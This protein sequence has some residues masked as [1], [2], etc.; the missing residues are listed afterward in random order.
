ME[1]FINEGFTFDDVLLI[2]AKSDVVPSEVCLKTRLSDKI[3][4]NIPIISAAMDTVTESKMA[5]AVATQG[6]VGIIHKNMSI[7]MQAAEVGKV[8]RYESGMVTNPL[9]L[10]PTTKVADALRIMQEQNISSFPIIFK[11]KVVGI[12]T[13]R[14]LRFIE[15]DSM[16]VE[17]VMTPKAKLVTGKEG[18]TPEL[19]RD[20][21]HKHRIEKL[22]ILNKRGELLGLITM[23]DIMK[24]INY[25]NACIDE[26][27]RLIVGAAIGTSADSMERLEEL[28]KAGVDIITVDTAHGHSSGVLKMVKKVKTRF[29]D[30]TVVGGNIATGDAARD[31]INAGADSI[32]VGI[33]PGSICT[34]RIVAGV[35]VPQVTAVNDCYQVARERNVT[36]IADG[37][38][39]Y[40]GDIA[41]AIA[42][43]ADVVMIG[44]LFAG[45]EESPGEKILFEGRQFKQYRGMGS[46]GAMKLGSKDRYF[47]S[48][49]TESEKMVP[50]GIEGRVPYRGYVSDTIYQ[51]IGGLRA[52]MGYCGCETIEKMKTATFTRITG[53]GLKESHPHDVQI[54]KEAPN[55]KLG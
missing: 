12:L 9:T 47:Q 33:G 44:S 39:K 36:V 52:A 22:P 51:F 26:K 32:K 31:L 40:S 35:G 53:A 45:C 55:Y 43:G 34:T 27:R 5:I 49:V 6:G 14:D 11:K 37:G 18:I 25:P 4:L 50:E 29:P 38:I 23:N 46:I 24:R 15:N 7:E 17:K 2:P 16:K 10:S 3:S 48:E 54:T 28:V 41:K 42:A 21:M 8:K 1:K 30:I 13:G 20:I 19:A